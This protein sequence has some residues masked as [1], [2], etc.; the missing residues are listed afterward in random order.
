MALVCL[1]PKTVEICYVELSMEERQLYDR[2]KEKT[3]ASLS[4]SF[5][6][7]INPLSIYTEMLSCILRLRQ[8]CA[9]MK[10]YKFQPQRSLTSSEGIILA[11]SYL[12]NS[13]LNLIQSVVLLGFSGFLFQCHNC[14]SL[15]LVQKSIILMRYCSHSTS[16]KLLPAI[17]V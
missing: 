16:K 14:F 6:C 11:Y 3:Q 13:F 9:D 10:L 15:N 5:A 7:E 8:I 1:P 2:E 4:T 17:H 12:L